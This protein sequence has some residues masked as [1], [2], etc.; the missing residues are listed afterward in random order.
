MLYPIELG[1]QTWSLEAGNIVGEVNDGWRIT[2][3]S[4]AHERA[5]LWVEGVCRLD[6]TVN[7]LIEV[8]RR[9]GLDQDA[10]IRRDIA[11]MYEQASSLRCRVSRSPRTWCWCRPGS[12]SASRRRPRPSSRA[13]AVICG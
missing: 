10:G 4:L 3:G 2:Q 9:R 12:S 11:T 13:P 6:A 1:V 5:G 8:A 7:G